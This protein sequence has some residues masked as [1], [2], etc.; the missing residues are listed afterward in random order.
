MGEKSQF[1]EFARR[2]HGDPSGGKKIMWIKRLDGICVCYPV[3]GKKFRNGM[4]ALVYCGG[5]HDSRHP[6][7]A[8]NYITWEVEGKPCGPD[9]EVF[10][11]E[12]AGRLAKR[13]IKNLPERRK[14]E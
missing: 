10:D 9:I 4:D 8:G 6:I 3:A 2:R 11:F 1:S 12:H 7:L 14:A 5:C 13:E